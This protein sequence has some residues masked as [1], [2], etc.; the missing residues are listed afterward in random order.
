MGKFGSGQD[1]RQGGEL[2]GLLQSWGEKMI[3]RGEE[4]VRTGSY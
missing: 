4:G 1:G 3:G 2:G